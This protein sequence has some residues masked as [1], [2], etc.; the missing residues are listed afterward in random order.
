MKRRPP[1]WVLGIAFL[2]G[3]LNLFPHIDGWAD[4]ESPAS[5]FLGF[6]HIRWDMAQYLAFARS[7]EETGAFAQPNPFVTEQ[8]DGRFVLP[9]LWA[10]G[11]LARVS[12]LDLVYSWHLL[13]ML[14]NW[15]F[16]L[17]VWWAAG[18]I[19][20]VPR[21][22][23]VA[24]LLVMF[25]SG[26]EWAWLVGRSAVGAAATGAEEVIFYWNWSSFG[27]T[28]MPIATFG[29]AFV[30]GALVF[31]L[32]AT[33][34]KRRAGNGILSAFLAVVAYLLHPYAGMLVLAVIGV[35][36]LSPWIAAGWS[37]R[38]LAPSEASGS[39]SAFGSVLLATVGIGGLSLW[40]SSD[41]VFAATSRH[42]LEWK[43]VYNPWW[44]PLLYGVAF[45]LALFGPRGIAMSAV[46]V[47]ARRLLGAWL[48][49]VAALALCPFLPGGKFQFYVHVPLS[50]MA[51]A[52]LEYLLSNS[53]LI[54]RLGAKRW[55]R[56]LFWGMLVVGS[57]STLVRFVP[58]SV[59]ENTK[60]APAAQLELLEVLNRLPAGG[61]LASVSSGN[62]VPWKAGK[63]VYAGHM[64]L[65]YDLDS[66]RNAIRTF[67]AGETTIS[68]KAS[69]L[70]A[71]RIRY[72]VED[73]WTSRF[74]RVDPNLGLNLVFQSEFGAIWETPFEP[75]ERGT[76]TP[77]R[78]AGGGT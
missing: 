74:G 70:K 39:L 71:E 42:I 66:R 14:A 46:D 24:F 62:L 73:P 55:M 76:G 19:F 60:D 58:G 49:V 8:Q 12:G 37:L 50:F 2:P 34:S 10:V 63:P 41:P 52:G 72:V 29:H 6:R 43:P 11:V 4:A 20:A 33:Q 7:S 65:S 3:L 9:Y 61:V 48:A 16:F 36:A 47:P 51:A 54:A 77:E 28:Q 22:R 75:A 67:V 25:G 44:Y 38:S 23:S 53:S 56:L 57:L 69:F 17:T 30:L 78:N 26:L 35:F 64:F 18:A 32:R 21:A 13:S 68:W 5:V 15:I 31:L 59:S 1:L 27:A 40:S 45:P